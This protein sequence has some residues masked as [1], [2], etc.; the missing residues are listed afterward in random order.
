NS[1]FNSS[2]GDVSIRYDQFPAPNDNSYGA[3]AVGWGT[4]GHKF[5]DLVGSDHAGFSVLN[6]SNT[7]VLDFN[8]DSISTKTGTPSASAS[9]GTVG[10][11]GKITIGSL[12]AADLTFDTSFARDLNNL[13][14]FTGG[15]QTVGTGVANLLVDSPPTQDP[16]GATPSAYLLTPAAAAVFTT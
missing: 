1:T 8:I 13:G 14:Y 15:V 16:S 4:K 2:T 10:G 5:N 3:N 6:P 11:D 12:T 7:D 9:L